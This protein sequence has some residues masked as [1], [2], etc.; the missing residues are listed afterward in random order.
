MNHAGTREQSRPLLPGPVTTALVQ[1]ERVLA[2]WVPYIPMIAVFSY[3]LFWPVTFP[4]P[5]KTHI[6][7]QNDGEL[8]RQLSLGFSFAIAALVMFSQRGR[9]SAFLWNNKLLL[10]LLLWALLSVSWSAVPVLSFKR[11]IQFAGFLLVARVAVIGEH[12]PERTLAVLRTLFAL[13]VF[14]SLAMVLLNPEAGLDASR[15]AWRGIHVHKNTLG[16]VATFAAVLWLPALLTATGPLRKGVVTAVISVAL[17]LVLQSDSKSSQI[18]LA[19][20]LGIWLWLALPFRREIKF[21]IAPL[22]LLVTL[23]WLFALH[24][25]GV[26]DLFFA[27]IERDSSLTG[28][29]LL[30]QE[31]LDQ[32]GLHSLYGAGYNGF[33]TSLNPQARLLVLRIGWDPGQAHNGYLDVLN[34]L[35][36]IGAG[37]FLLLLLQMSVRIVR[38]MRVHLVVGQ[39]LLLLFVSQV[40]FNIT[41]TGF[42]RG[43]T[44]GWI[45]FLTTAI[46]ANRLGHWKEVKAGAAHA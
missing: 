26:T 3:I 7:V 19:V 43:S 25:G 32:F 39:T 42:C 4:P 30:W 31:L 37:I 34:E 29:T 14:A 8:S 18:V 2:V 35:G 12:G 23:F 17:L 24:S 40:L 9:L 27:A 46:L 1:L 6:Q 21:A 20:L 10:L 44:L 45:L 41:E 13:A 22:P 11:W 38:S 28:R 16:Q 5:G 33:W 15:Q 36:I